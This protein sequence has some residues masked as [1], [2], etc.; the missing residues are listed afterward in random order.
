M[1]IDWVRRAEERFRHCLREA[2]SDGLNP[3]PL[4]A[5]EEEMTI[6]YPCHWLYEDKT[7]PVGTRL[8][9]FQCS[10]RARVAV[11]LGNEAMAEVRGQAAR[12]LKQV[13]GTRPELHNALAVVIVQVG[14]PLEPF[15]VQPLKSAMKRAKAAQ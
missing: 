1:G 15:Y 6:T 5:P 2:A 11:L 7:S 8:T 9:I 4:L 3:G 13:F 14:E 10:D 12:D